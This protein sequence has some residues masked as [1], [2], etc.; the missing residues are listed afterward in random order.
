MPI[1]EAMACGIPAIA[2]DWSGPTTFL[3]HDNGYP[4]PIRGLAPADAGGVYGVGA[5]WA[6]PDADAL[7]DLLRR[8]VQ[9]PE[10]RRRKGL[11]AAA[12]ATRWTWD[13][14]VDAVYRRLQALRVEG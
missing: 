1:L 5:Q 9:N 14:A 8:V 7:V 2:T 13:R 6:E 3:N 10:E 4:L 11:R 12:D